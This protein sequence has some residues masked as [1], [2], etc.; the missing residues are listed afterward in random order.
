MLGFPGRIFTNIDTDGYKQKG[1]DHF[2]TGDD[3]GLE[4]SLILFYSKL[5]RIHAVHP[6]NMSAGIVRISIVESG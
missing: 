4:Y 3:Q 1:P 5:G 6:H 2:S